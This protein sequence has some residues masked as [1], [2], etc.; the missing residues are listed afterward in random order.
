MDKQLFDIG[1][2]EIKDSKLLQKVAEKLDAIVVDA[3]FSPR[4]RNPTWN[5]SN[6][7]KLLG[8][9]YE[10][11]QALGNRNYK[12]GPVEFV[13]TEEAIREVDNL[14]TQKPVILMCMCPNRERCHR[15]EFARIFEK[16]TGIHSTP[17]TLELCQELVGEV[18]PQLKLFE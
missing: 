18:D 14:L 2:S 5:Q 1:Y 9:R 4:S 3:R 10:H 8:E 17:L 12:G 15:T 6:L 11:V 16:R 7:V 13:N